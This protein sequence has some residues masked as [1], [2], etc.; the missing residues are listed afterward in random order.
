MR[1]DDPNLPHLLVIADALGE[2]CDQV[3]FLGGAVVGL[4]VSDPLAESVRATYDVDA[5]VNLDWAR[6][7]GIEARVESQGF[8]REMRSGVVC[9]WVHQ[10]SGVLFDLMPVDAGVLGFSNRWYAHAVET[11]QVVALSDRLS[12]RLVTATA[13]VATKLEAFVTRGNSDFLS[14]HD[15]EDVLNVVDGRAELVEE[16]AVEHAD[17]RQWVADVFA[18]LVD[19]PAFVNALPGMVAEPERASVVLQRLRTITSA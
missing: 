11:A 6:F 3:V 14:S 19:N 1:S 5:V 10:A 4:L 7:R 12:I 9:R 15:L 17:L 18:G 8:A 13:F 16:L 2:L